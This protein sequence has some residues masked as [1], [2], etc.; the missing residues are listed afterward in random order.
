M[1][2][3]QRGNPKN[4]RATVKAPV[5][6]KTFPYAAGLCWCKQ[7]A[8]SCYQS[9]HYIYTQTH[10]YH[11][12][13]NRASEREREEGRERCKV[14]RTAWRGAKGN[15]WAHIDLTS[16]STCR[17]DAFM[18]E[19]HFILISKYFEVAVLLF[20]VLTAKF[21][22]RSKRAAAPLLHWQQTL[23]YMLNDSSLNIFMPKEKHWVHKNHKSEW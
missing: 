12:S 1:S 21:S 22:I 14:R 7:P 10:S 3:S 11:I 19:T 16:A 9:S 5:R 13:Q 6:E 4:I 18:T 2:V 23:I 15:S 17:L 20:S 8:S